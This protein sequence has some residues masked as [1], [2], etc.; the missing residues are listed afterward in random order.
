M[1]LHAVPHLVDKDW[2]S[3]RNSSPNPMVVT[4]H[5]KIWA[6]LFY[7]LQ[8]CKQGKYL[9]GVKSR[10]CTVEVSGLSSF[11]SPSQGEF[12]DITDK[13]GCSEASMCFRPIHSDLCFSLQPWT[14]RRP[15]KS[16]Q[17]CWRRK[18]HVFPVKVF[19][20]PCERCFWVFLASDF[21]LMP[22]Y[23]TEFG[24]LHFY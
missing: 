23:G 5:Y 14:S 6:A 13:K 1:V 8:E 20:T 24:F 17:W 11:W 10:H 22:C 12:A 7:P 3:R 4:L 9:A 15:W 16:L 18:Q 2:G 21:L 19:L